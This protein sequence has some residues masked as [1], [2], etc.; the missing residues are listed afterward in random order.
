MT[1]TEAT[2]I[3]HCEGPWV[4]TLCNLDTGC[5]LEEAATLVIGLLFDAHANPS[6]GAAQSFCCL[7]SKLG[8][9]EVCTAER[10]AQELLAEFQEKGDG[11][12]ATIASL[13]NAQTLRGCILETLRL[14]SHSIGAIREARQNV[15]LKTESAEFKIC[16]GE[17]VVI[18]HIAPHRNGSIWG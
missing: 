5:T 2:A 14:S 17:T 11:G 10:E 15:V 8:I 1:K 16:E 7:Y 18:S 9:D 13:L 12:G 6:I 4:R 3:D